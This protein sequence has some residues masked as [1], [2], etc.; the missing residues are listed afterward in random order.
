METNPILKETLLTAVDNQLRGGDPPE[1]R[2]T[3]D[4]LIAEGHPDKEARRLIGIALVTEIHRIM[5][6]KKPFDQ[7]N[8]AALLRKLPQMPWE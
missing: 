1:A 6:E 8:Y 2:E 5:T 3:Y 4:R 7:D